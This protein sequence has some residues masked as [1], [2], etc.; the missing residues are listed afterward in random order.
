MTLTEH[1]EELRWC[2]LRSVIAVLVGSTVCYYF[3]N[4]IFA[5]MVAPLRENLQPG[6]GLIGTSVTEAFFSEIKVAIAAGVL[7]TCPYIFYQIWRFIAPG[8]SGGEKKLVL[9]FVTCA[10][11]FFLGGA[12]FCYRVVLPVAFKYFVEQYNTMGVLPAIRIGEYFTFFFR[13]VL[14][15][16]ITF[17]LP[18]F[19]FFL[20]RLGLWNYRLMISS[21]RYAIIGIFILA[22]IL[23]PTPD[24]INQS[25][26]A[27]PMLVLY[28]ASIGV[29]YI[30]RRTD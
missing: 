24:V 10:T 13:M 3:S 20:V 18:V 27:L 22:A 5:F 16:G 7:F 9:P 14:A 15:F 29:A 2:L 25:L 11:L 4:A 1:L 23:T 6:Q 28:I 21:F 30:W 17:E 12:Y 19:T 8:L 26:L